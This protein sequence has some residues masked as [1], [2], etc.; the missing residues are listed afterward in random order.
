MNAGLVT[1]A[2]G[3]INPPCRPLDMLFEHKDMPASSGDH[4]RRGGCAGEFAYP[5]GGQP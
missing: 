3:V 4:A 5:V 2:V 1:T